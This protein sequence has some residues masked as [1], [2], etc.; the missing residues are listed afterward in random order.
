[1]LV[2]NII[3]SKSKISE[4]S[5]LKQKKYRLEHGLVVV[6]GKRL[7]QQLAHWGI[8]PLEL[9]GDNPFPDFESVPCFHVHAGDLERICSSD[10]PPE[11]AALYPI[12]KPDPIS[13]K[14]ALYLED[15]SD[16]GNLGTIFRIACAFGIDSLL[17]SPSCCEISSPKVIR[18]SL[19][20]VYQVPFTIGELDDLIDP[21]TFLAALM[22]D[23]EKALADFR[24]GSFPLVMAIGNEAHGL[25]DKTLRRANLGLGIS[26]KGGMESL[27]AAVCAG[28]VAYHLSGVP[29]SRRNG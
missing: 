25:S 9:Y 4:L 10:H 22:M 5:K 12:P 19:G 11:V 14:T 24:P 28:I 8:M 2:D 23:G 17:L 13:Y 3:L 1:M 6:E 16:P 27:N 29:A 26:M 15:I 18:A 7:L 20:A 21:Q